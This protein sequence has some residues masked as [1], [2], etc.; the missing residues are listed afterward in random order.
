MWDIRGSLNGYSCLMFPYVLWI[1]FSAAITSRWNVFPQ[2]WPV[3]YFHLDF[4]INAHDGLGWGIP[5]RVR[6]GEAVACPW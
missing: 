4:R 2:F 5:N 3:L 6:R 1:M